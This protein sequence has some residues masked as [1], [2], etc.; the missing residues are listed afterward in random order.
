MEDSPRIGFDDFVSVLKNAQPSAH[1]A[2]CP[3]CDGPYF[4]FV[5]EGKDGVLFSCCNRPSCRDSKVFKAVRF[6]LAVRRERGA[7]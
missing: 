6:K 7:A 2:S 5:R 3:A 4:Q 1:L